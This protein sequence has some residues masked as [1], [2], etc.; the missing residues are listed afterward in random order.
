MDNITV[1]IIVGSAAI[2]SVNP[3]AFAVLI[4]LLTYLMFLGSKKKVIQIGII[5][6]SVVYV[7]YFLAGVGF[8][9]A[10]QSFHITRLIY[11]I[12]AVA[13]IIAGLINIKDFFWYGKGISLEIPQSKKAIIEKY[14]KKAS[15]PAAVVLGFLV[16]AFELPCTGG[17]YLAILGLLSENTDKVLGIFYLL[18]YNLI[19]I[20]PLIIIVILVVG[21]TKKTIEL[22]QWRLKKR[23]WMRLAMG[24]TM[25][26][27]GILMLFGVI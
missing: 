19:F 14:V 22:E 15:I 17:I 18:L 2:D 23:K 1:P 24:L 13:V 6:I 10:I 26:T 4:F 27:L 3:C 11:Y 8:L 20:L 5:Y 12:S 25:L 16:A 7:T 21:G 9:S